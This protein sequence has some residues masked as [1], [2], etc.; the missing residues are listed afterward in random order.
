MK[1]DLRGAS[2]PADTSLTSAEVDELLRRE[3]EAL[4]LVLPSRGREPLHPLLIVVLEAV[5]EDGRRRLARRPIQDLAGA[6]DTA[7]ILRAAGV[8]VAESNARV[9]GAMLIRK[10]WAKDL[11]HAEAR[12][13]E[14]RPIRSAQDADRREALVL[15][16][17]SID[18]RTACAI[19]SFHREERGARLGPWRFQAC[20][21]TD[22]EDEDNPLSFFFLGFLHEW[23][24][25][26][27]A[28]L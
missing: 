8:A 24:R 20:Q 19:A 6:T 10:A 17:R 15:W 23:N 13:M 14:V 2:G 27:R 25:R 18:R 7:R 12:R 26:K 11:S 1:Q 21:P 22:G 28:T 16:F 3:T 5:D 4:D 9:A